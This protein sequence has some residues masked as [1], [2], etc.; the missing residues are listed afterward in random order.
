[1]ASFCSQST[2]SDTICPNSRNCTAMLASLAS[3]APKVKRDAETSLGTEFDN[4]RKRQAI[5]YPL[6]VM[7]FQTL[8]ERRSGTIFIISIMKLNKGF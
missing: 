3:L 4:A 6:N 1:M 8:M 7:K 5:N 2:Q